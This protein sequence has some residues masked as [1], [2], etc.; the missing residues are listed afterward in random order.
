MAA[1]GSVDTLL[2]GYKRE[3][4]E[5]KLC[6][7]HELFLS[8]KEKGGSNFIASA[9]D[10]AKENLYHKAFYNL[11]VTYSNM[12]RDEAFKWMLRADLYNSHHA[13]FYLAFHY[14]SGLGCA[15][16]LQ[17]A[18]DLY[19]KSWSKYSNPYSKED[20]DEVLLNVEKILTLKKFANPGEFTAI[21]DAGKFLYDHYS[22]NLNQEKAKA[23]LNLVHAHLKKVPTASIAAYLPKNKILLN[24][25][26]L[27]YSLSNKEEHNATVF[28]ANLETDPENSEID[29]LPFIYSSEIK[30]FST[31]RDNI[32]ELYKKA[33]HLE[34]Y[35]Y[36]ILGI[37]TKAACCLYLKIYILTLQG[38]L[39]KPTFSQAMLNNLRERARNYFSYIENNAE[40]LEERAVGK[41]ALEMSS[42]ILLDELMKDRTLF[43]GSDNVV[44]LLTRIDNKLW[45]DYKRRLEREAYTHF[46]S[47]DYKTEYNHIKTCFENRLIRFITNDEKPEDKAASKNILLAVKQ[48][49]SISSPTNLLIKNS[50][51]MVIIKI[52]SK[53]CLAERHKEVDA[54]TILFWRKN[55]K[56]KP[57]VDRYKKALDLLYPPKEN[58]LPAARSAYEIFKKLVLE[59]KL[60]NKLGVNI[61]R[62]WAVTACSHLPDATVKDVEDSI[63]YC[64][65]IFLDITDQ[66]WPV[67]VCMKNLGKLVK[68]LKDESLSSKY[69]AAFERFDLKKQCIDDIKKFKNAPPAPLPSAPLPEER[70]SVY[71]NICAEGQSVGLISSATPA[72]FI[73]PSSSEIPPLRE[74]VVPIAASLPSAPPPPVIMT[75]KESSNGKP[76][77]DRRELIADAGGTTSEIEQPRVVLS[78]RPPAVAPSPY[79]EPARPTILAH[80]IP[81][82]EN[83]GEEGQPS[84]IGST[85]LPET[86]ALPL[87]AQRLSMYKLYESYELA[88]SKT[89]VKE[90]A[91]MQLMYHVLVNRDVDAYDFLIKIVI[92]Q[93]NIHLLQFFTNEIF[94][95]VNQLRPFVIDRRIGLFEP[96]IEAN[97]VALTQLFSLQNDVETLYLLFM[98]N[99][100]EDIKTLAYHHLIDHALGKQNKRAC[101]ILS[102]I[103]GQKKNTTLVI[104]FSQIGATLGLGALEQSPPDVTRTYTI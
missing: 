99:P 40:N 56:A 22:F 10:C 84:P 9:I 74:L 21:L 52:L 4:D 63:E 96:G 98:R 24:F 61:A 26:Y 82:L 29:S 90:L 13:T 8:E 25:F 41:W 77:D 37:Q 30:D 42:S 58:D 79:P 2:E 97:P 81:V 103:E 49:L 83:S 35:K 38:H 73:T 92:K 19:K 57:V 71:P 75:V 3:F 68:E 46:P 64:E 54:W 95:V 6:E 80:A 78:E 94:A 67:L 34:S 39:L 100:Q 62:Q 55:P 36:F 16:D 76:N 65:Q 88:E 53:E 102:V 18:M 93:N 45:T 7:T 101:Q 59:N 15:I 50:Y 51:W 48:F 20:C 104:F 89:E 23:I 14:Q 47:T 66:N 33:L 91:Y 27:Q 60:Q 72:T 12:K 44:Y 1:S 70:V 28:K 87:S 17:Q 32:A 86:M 5:L 85:A 69:V 31:C 43:I 11:A